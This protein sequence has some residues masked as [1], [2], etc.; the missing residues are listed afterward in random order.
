MHADKTADLVVGVKGL[1]EVFNPSLVRTYA[2]RPF[3]LA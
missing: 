1:I 2:T 3:V